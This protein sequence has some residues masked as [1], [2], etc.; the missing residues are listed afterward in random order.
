M[1]GQLETIPLVWNGS[2]KPSGKKDEKKKEQERALTEEKN[3]L[4]TKHH[5]HQISGLLG[6]MLWQSTVRIQD[7]Q[8]LGV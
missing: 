4:V 1:Q 8:P 7:L 2:T 3:G 5:I 6:Q